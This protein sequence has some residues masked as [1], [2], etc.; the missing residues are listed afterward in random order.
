MVKMVNQE[1]NKINNIKKQMIERQI[2]ELKIEHD[3]LVIIMESAFDRKVFKQMEQSTKRMVDAN[4]SQ[5]LF[6]CN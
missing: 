4:Y 2:N 6:A 1:L 5:C 3:N